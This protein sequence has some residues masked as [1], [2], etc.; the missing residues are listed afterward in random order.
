MR[1]MVPSEKWEK[2]NKDIE[3][4]N[5]RKTFYGSFT[6][7]STDWSDGEVELE[8]ELFQEGNV[9]IIRE[10]A[11]EGREN[12]GYVRDAELIGTAEDGVLTISAG[13]T[14]ENDIVICIVVYTGCE[15]IPQ[16]EE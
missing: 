1:I 12:Y 10:D 16:E 9:I 5:G 14:P 15:E 11:S 8:N 6:I 2:L 4:L 3:N 7:E 13:T